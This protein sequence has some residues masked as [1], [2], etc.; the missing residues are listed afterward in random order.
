[1]SWASGTRSL[2]RGASDPWRHFAA[3]T[4]VAEIDFSHR[5]S[6]RYRHP[7]IGFQTM[8]RA[9]VIDDDSDHRALLASVIR[10]AGWE[11][12]EAQDGEQGVDLA[13]STRPDLVLCDLLMP[14]YNGFQVCRSLRKDGLLSGIHIVVTSGRVFDADR[15]SAIEAGANEYLTKPVQQEELS[16]VLARLSSDNTAVETPT[17]RQPVISQEAATLKFWGVRGSIPSPGPGTVRYGGNTSCVEVRADGE[18]I[19][20]DAGTGLRALGRQLMEEFNDQPLSLTLLLTHTHWDHIQGLPYFAPIYSPN[21]QLRIFGYEGARSSL[22]SAL[23]GQMENPYFPVGFSEIPGNV[24]IEELRD[25]EFRV[26]KVRVEVWFANHPGICV[27]YR[28]NTSS[29]S[30]GYFPD[31]EPPSRLLKARTQSA[32]PVGPA[33]EY[34]EGAE[35]RLVDFL[36]GADVLIMDAQY[37]AEEYERHVGW[38]HGC[39]DDVVRLALASKV[40]QL[41]L[42]HHDPDHDD[43]KM[44]QMEAHARSLVRQEGG[45]LDVE[46]AREGAVVRLVTSP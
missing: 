28:L 25:M 7:G 18:I 33:K 32:A 14:G 16:A 8:K 24:Q 37:D 12:L 44:A 15:Q 19:L 35:R 38:G 17:L 21:C 3:P 11:V 4:A 42:F 39:V 1:M 30:I 31:N 26:G 45:E 29:G 46:A 2:R 5:S 20:L 10:A 43:A 22:S 9:L 27:G 36:Q 40:R 23:S 41:R 6:S 34:A 13:R